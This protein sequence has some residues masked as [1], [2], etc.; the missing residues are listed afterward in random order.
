MKEKKEWRLCSERY[1]DTHTHTHTHT[2]LCVV[3]VCMGCVPVYVCGCAHAC[4]CMLH[5]VH[6]G[7]YMHSYVYCVMHMD[8]VCS[9]YSFGGMYT[10][11]ASL[12][13]LHNF[14]HVCR[15]GDRKWCSMYKKV[16]IYSTH[17]HIKPQRC[18]NASS[19][20]GYM[21]HDDGRQSSCIAAPWMHMAYAAERW[22][23]FAQCSLT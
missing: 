2:R 1:F 20:D 3:Y 8:H 11:H 9:V 17:V 14:S 22:R 6:R 13:V 5:N 4:V 19:K 10:V 7:V 23:T 16:W 12:G 21:W 18:T 15:R